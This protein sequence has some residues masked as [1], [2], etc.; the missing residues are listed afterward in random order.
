MVT[1]THRRRTGAASLIP[2][3]A[4]PGRMPTY[5]ELAA[6]LE[7]AI[8]SGTL[9]P[10]SRLP[11]QRDLAK[12]RAINLSTVS[13]AYAELKTRRLALGST[14]RGTIVMHPPDGAQWPSVHSD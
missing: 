8:R 5:L 2:P 12:E 13:R 11:A 1:Q 4:K 7:A 9:A 6:E 14:K 10:G 3:A